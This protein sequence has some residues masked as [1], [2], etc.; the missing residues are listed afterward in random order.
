MQIP[1]RHLIQLCQRVGTALRAG[2]DAR[3]VWEMEAGRG[4]PA[5]RQYAERIKQKVAAGEAVATAMR[6]C[7]GYFPPL[8]VQMVEV[9]EA[10]G[11]LDEVLLRLAEHYEHQAQMQRQFLFG[12]A[13]PAFQLGFAVLIIGILIAAFGIIADV[14][15]GEPIDVLGLGLSGVSG[16]LTFWM[17]CGLF[18]GATG[19][20]IYALLRGWFGPKPLLFAMRVPMIGKA[21]E[22]LALARLTWSFAM[23][24]DSGMPAR[25]TVE[26][27]LAAS[28]NVYYSSHTREI[29]QAVAAGNEFHEAFKQSG[30]F[31]EEFIFSLEAAELAGATTESLLRLTREYEDRARNAIRMLTAAST[32][33][34][35]V[36]VG[37]I[38]VVMIFRLAMLYIGPIYDALEMVK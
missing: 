5:Y 23:G 15:G 38:L 9:G 28:Q 3:K 20:A 7:D 12:I 17:F 30:A 18:L 37:A 29:S 1:S 33:G 24:L 6:Q 19:A 13:W 16:M 27:A 31:P 2:V 35:M 22:S 14:A 11:K 10:T 36:L 8:M 4:T 32:V 26:L 21:L 25:R 34:F